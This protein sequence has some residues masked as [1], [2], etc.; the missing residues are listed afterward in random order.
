M[1]RAIAVV[2]P[3]YA[4]DFE[5]WSSLK[6]LTSTKKLWSTILGATSIKFN[7]KKWSTYQ[8]HIYPI[9]PRFS[10]DLYFSKILLKYTLSAYVCYWLKK[11][12]IVQKSK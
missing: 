7:F 3:P 5:F 1:H 12:L 10:I 11:R 2:M 8:C 4:K 6:N 9:E